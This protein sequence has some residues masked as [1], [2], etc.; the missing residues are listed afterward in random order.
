MKKFYKIRLPKKKI[1]IDVGANTGDWFTKA[2]KNIRIQEFMHLNQSKGL[3]KK[4]DVKI[5]NKA[6][7]LKNNQI[8]TFN[9]TRKTVTSSLLKQE[10]EYHR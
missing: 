8:K 4:K 9:I 2:K 6:I 1:F 10:R 3:Q 7:D 5:I